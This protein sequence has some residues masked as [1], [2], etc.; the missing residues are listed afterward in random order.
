MKGKA[1]RLRWYR[2]ALWSPAVLA[3]LAAASGSTSNESF[4]QVPPPVRAAAR[5]AWTPLSQALNATIGSG[6]PT[7]VV[8]TSR[9][10]P[11]SLQFCRALTYSSEVAG[12]AGSLQVAEMAS[13]LYKDQVKTLGVR[14]FPTLVLYRRGSR[15]LEVA[16]YTSGLTDPRDVVRWIQSLGVQARVTAPADSAVQRTAQHGAMASD[17]AYPSA[18]YPQPAPPSKQPLMPPPQ[19][20]YV[21][22]A[23]TPPP[24]QMAPPQQ[25]AV[26][27]PAPAPVYVQPPT[28]TMVVQQAP[29]QIIL[30]PAPRPRSR[31]PW[32]PRPRR[33]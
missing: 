3:A 6:V 4:G 24:V 28:P 11:G 19:P 7:L 2:R 9:T 14:T 17:Q 21:P 31:S 1:M 27:Y 10:D 33:R 29:Q 30:A 12:L 18:Q 25:Y 16:S 26:P 22:P 15:G 13:D 5:L 32:H 23:Y 20:P 8:V